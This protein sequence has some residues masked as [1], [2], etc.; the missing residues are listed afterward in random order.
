MCTVISLGSYARYMVFPQMFFVNM[1]SKVLGMVN[2]LQT[3]VVNFIIKSDNFPIICH[4]PYLRNMRAYDHDFWYT[5]VK[6]WYLQV[7]FFIFLKI[8]IFWVVR[9]IKRKKR[10]K[11][12]KILSVMLH[13][14]GTIH[15]MIVIYGA[16]MLHDNI[17]WCFFHFSKIFIFGV[18]S[19]E[20]GQKMVQNGKRF[21]VVLHISVN[22][23]H[24]I[25][26]YVMNVWKDNISRNFFQF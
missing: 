8:L 26:I 1:N 25:V 5:I 20:K 18:V 16:H 10:S 6:W 3:F 13:I 2:F 9:G 12:Q 21:S 14:A 15:Y 17:S 11:W 4:V 23:H 24:M 22:I 7:F 19:W